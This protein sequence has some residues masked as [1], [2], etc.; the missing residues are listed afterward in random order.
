MKRNADSDIP[1]KLRLQTLPAIMCFLIRAHYNSNLWHQFFSAYLD[2][3]VSHRFLCLVNKW[4][5]HFFL[6]SILFG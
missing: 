3:E 4:S 6:K 2:F 1:Y 5:H